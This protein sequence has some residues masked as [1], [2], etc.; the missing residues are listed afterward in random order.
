MQELGETFFEVF[1]TPERNR[2]EYSGMRTK[3]NERRI[4]EKE[5]PVHYI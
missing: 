5:R 1:W 3:K 2:L 4:K